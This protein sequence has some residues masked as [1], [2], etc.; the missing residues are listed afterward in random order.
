MK[1]NAWSGNDVRD[2]FEHST[3]GESCLFWGI[4]GSEDAPK[5]ILLDG[6]FADFCEIFYLYVLGEMIPILTVAP[7]FPG[8]LTSII[9]YNLWVFTP[10]DLFKVIFSDSTMAYHHFSTPFGR[11]GFTFYKHR[12]VANPSIHCVLIRLGVECW[13]F[14]VNDSHQIGPKSP[15]TTQNHTT[16]QPMQLTYPPGNQEISHR[17]RK[18][19]IFKSDEIGLDMWSF[20]GGYP[21]K[22]IVHN[23]QASTSSHPTLLFHKIY[24][25]H[26]MLLSFLLFMLRLEHQKAVAELILLAQYLG[27]LRYAASTGRRKVWI[28]VDVWMVGASWARAMH[29]GKSLR[30]NYIVTTAQSSGICFW[31]G[32]AAGISSQSLY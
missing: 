29:I 30:S 24:S 27:A 7:I 32:Q 9:M 22:T 2:E 28:V 3:G 21:S 15:W 6:G 18:I 23:R 10:F 4:F 1:T 26:K 14:A 5:L 31:H 19:I 13:G 25:F 8:R 11:I 16:T 17:Q 20:L 12:R